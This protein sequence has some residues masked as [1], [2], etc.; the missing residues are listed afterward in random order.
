MRVPREST[1]RFGPFHHGQSPRWPA[2]R[3]RSFRAWICLILQIE[4]TDMAERFRAEAADFEIVF[5]DRER[6]AQLAHVWREELSLEAETWPPRKH[7]ADVQ[8]FP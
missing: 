1:L 2:L 4:E 8:S 3:L 7:A 6:L 5:H